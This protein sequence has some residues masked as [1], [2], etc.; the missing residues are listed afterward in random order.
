ML[1]TRFISKSYINGE[2]ELEVLKEVSLNFASKGLYL[3]LGPS[4]SGKTTLLSML[5]G[6]DIPDKGEILFNGEK[7]ELKNEKSANQYRQNIVSFIF[8]ED[9]LIDYL[10]LKD[11]LTLKSTKTSKEVEKII[12]K[13]DIEK[14]INKK[15]S[16][17]S[18]GEKQRCA[19]GRAILS[20]SKIVLC[21]EPTASLDFENAKN[22]MNILKDLSKDKLVIVVSH[23]EEL[24]LPFTD[25]VIRIK[26]GRI[27][28]D[29]SKDVPLDEGK[30]EINNKKNKIYSSNIF[31]RS[32]LHSKH[33]FK[34]SFLI[35]FLGLI[36]FFCVSIIIGIASGSRKII[37]RVS[38]DLI[39]NAPLTVSSYYE[40]ITTISLLKESNYEAKN[41]L[42][43][44]EDN[45]I[46]KSLHKNI[47][48]DEFVEYITKNPAES[49]Y[50]SFNNDIKYSLIYESG[51][52][53]KLYNEF[54]SKGLSDYIDVFFGKR[55]VLSELIYD[56][57]FF[58]NRFINLY[59]NYPQNE[60]E[61]VVL[62]DQGN[63]VHSDVAKILDMKEGDDISKMLNK[64]FYMANNDD[65]YEENDSY[66][67][68]GHFLKDLET[69]KA[70]GKDLRAI[71]NLIV[72]YGNEYYEGNT[73]KQKYYMDKIKGLF[74][75]EKETRAIKAY[76]ALENPNELENIVNKYGEDK[77]IKIVGVYKLPANL[78]FPEKGVGILLN[79]DL[80]KK[81]REAN[82]K[83]KIA[84]E[85][86]E[87]IVLGNKTSEMIFP[88]IYN[89]ID[90]A[91]KRTGNNLE[92][93]V[94]AYVNF[95]EERKFFSVNNE[96]SS[97]EIYAPTVKVKNDY[98]EKINQFNIDKEDDFQ[99]KTLDLSKKVIM[100]FDEYFGVIE[101]ALY[102]ISFV[103]LIISGSLSL[104]IIFSMVVMRIKEIGIY[105]AS[106]YS[107]KY[108]FAL[109][110]I[111]NVI[112]GFISGVFGVIF[113]QIATPFINNYFA[114]AAK[115]VNLSNIVN[116][117][118]GWSLIIIAIS[119]V[120]SFIAA[121]IPS[122]IYSR[123]KPKEVMKL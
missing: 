110:E 43:I 86:D 79:K 25:Y 28:S 112:L 69:L 90:K 41:E 106:G 8:Q 38:S 39:H 120:T 119:I 94:L 14:L 82:S 47:I 91:N 88:D 22:V 84:N 31:K 74:K 98:E 85:I 57:E 27:V 18:G 44:Q 105:R 26:D 21:D 51:G 101:K 32:L 30:I 107:F 67:V 17:L 61:A 93:N 10:N 63:K 71:T 87:H 11:N 46:A 52:Y 2:K 53:K 89:F 113:A 58:E 4:G 60:N 5:G 12:K 72:A 99:I 3:I 65:L 55:T 116:L 59:G 6:L 117:S 19:I 70:E 96:Y 100:Y 29:S 20:D 34:Q 16:E 40:N 121:F 95:F 108:V 109:L 104:A 36:A 62:L 23:D 83:S 24:C 45:S 97:V 80:L 75:D 123:K 77:K 42:G 102:V 122:F 50:F 81:Q 92:E 73:E 56:K 35:T 68:T 78:T 64:T 37:S 115:G 9:N 54:G 111:E 48:T 76:S 49:T 15:P 13:L 114:N 66:E 1:E 103:A 118:W 7:L 33:K